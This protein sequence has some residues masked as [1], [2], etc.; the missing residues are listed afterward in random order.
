MINNA[1]DFCLDFIVCFVPFR[2][3]LFCFVFLWV[4]FVPSTFHI[5][6]GRPFLP[7]FLPSFFLRVIYIYIIYIYI[8]IYIYTW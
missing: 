2:F 8:Y 4:F 3:V 7:S 5:A 1:L 6:F